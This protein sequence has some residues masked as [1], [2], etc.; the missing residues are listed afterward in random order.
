MK[1][2]SKFNLHYFK[3]AWKDCLPK[4]IAAAAQKRLE[5]IVI[6]YIRDAIELTGEG[7]IAV[8]GGVFANV[9]LNQTWE[10]SNVE[11]L[12]VY[13]NMN[14]ACLSTGA[15]LYTYYK[16]VT[17]TKHIAKFQCNLYCGPRYSKDEIRKSLEFNRLQD[18]HKKNIEKEIAV[19]L[20][21]GKIIGHYYGNMEYGR[22]LGNR[23]IIA[24]PTDKNINSYLNKKLHRTEF[25]P[26]APSILEDYAHE[27]LQ[28]WSPEHISS[29]F[30]TMTY[31]V[32]EKFKNNAPAAV[33]I[34]NTARPQIVKKTY[35]PRFYQIIKDFYDLSGIPVII[36]T[37]FNMHEEPI[38]CSPDDAIK[39]FKESKIDILVLDDFWVSDY[40]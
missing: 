21:S 37:S 20:N 5:D 23:L 40:P 12:Y 11:N 35:N 10:L 17:R 29:N 33:H 36:N 26:F 14:D 3:D 39:A 7:R 1:D 24:S 8:A 15:A 19:A 25:M 31:E 18:E 16:F 2:N 13:P 30:M 27:Y 22:A 9:R 4:D 34:D 6:A 32:T 28:R 38:V